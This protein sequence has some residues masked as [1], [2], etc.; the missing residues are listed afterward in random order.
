INSWIIGMPD[1]AY[2]SISAQ[3]AVDFTGDLIKETFREIERLCAEKISESEIKTVKGY[4]LGEL[5]RTFDNR[6]TLA[7]ALITMIV[8]MLPFD[9]FDRKSEAVNDVS[10]TALLDIAQKN[11]HPETMF[12]V[13]A[14]GGKN[15][16]LI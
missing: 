16:I 12:T 10:S 3:S 4:M 8:N 5:A 7:D 14:G 13:V 15:K 11:F 2:I 6:F 1:A 9:Y